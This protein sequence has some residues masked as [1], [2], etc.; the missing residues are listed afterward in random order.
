M[1]AASQTPSGVL[2][3]TSVSTTGSVAAK[4]GLVA[5]TSPAD[6]ER[7]MK[8][9]RETFNICAFSGSCSSVVISW[10]PGCR[11]QLCRI[12]ERLADRSRAG[13]LGAVLHTP[14]I[15]P[16]HLEQRLGDLT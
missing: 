14:P 11:W 3:V 9:R 4:D 16:T 2:T 15:L 5:A 1:N 8:S 13:P 12:R 7:A 6:T 10:P